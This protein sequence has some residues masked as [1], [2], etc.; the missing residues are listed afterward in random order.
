MGPHH[1]EIPRVVAKAVLLLE[2]A[3]VL[4]VDDDDA[5]VVK[6]G[7]HSGAGADQDGGAA[8]ATGQP[9]IEPLPVV[10]GGVHGHHGHVEAAPE[11]IDG[12][13]GEAYLRH[14]HQGLPARLEQGLED[15]QV[16]LCL[17]GAGDAVQQ[18]GAESVAL[19]GDSGHRQRLLAVETQPFSWLKMGGPVAVM[20]RL[21]TALLQQAF[22]LQRGEGGARNL[23]LLEGRRRLRPLAQQGEGLLLLGRPLDLVQIQGHARLGG[24]PELQFPVGGGLPLAH[25]HRQGVGQHFPQ[26]MLVVTGAPGHQRQNV[27]PEHGGAVEHPLQGL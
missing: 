25:Q 26:R 17:A 16:H 3:V 7:E 21:Q 23:L 2:G 13:G 12:L 1:G 14:H 22:L 9:G 5:E 20:A 24:E 11:A 18:E 27:G 10:H 6:R 8:V 15:A 4:L 19:A